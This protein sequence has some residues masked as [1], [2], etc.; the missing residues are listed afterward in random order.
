MNYLSSLADF[1]DLDSWMLVEE[2]A[3]GGIRWQRVALA[4]TMSQGSGI[5]LLHA[6]RLSAGLRNLPE[7]GVEIVHPNR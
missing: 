3:F 1:L 7:G 5:R 2:D 6:K 4:S